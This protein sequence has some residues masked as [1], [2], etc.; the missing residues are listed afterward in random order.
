MNEKETRTMKKI[1]ISG[2][3]TGDSGWRKKFRQAEEKLEAGGGWTVLS[4]LMVLKEI[5]YEDYMHI[6]FAMIDVCDAVFFLRDWRDS[7]GAAREHSYAQAMRKGLL[8]EE[9]ED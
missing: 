9:E 1:Y 6:D 7:P 3:I 2:K 5:G 8:Y 4:P